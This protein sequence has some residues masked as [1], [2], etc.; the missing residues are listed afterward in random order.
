MVVELLDLGQKDW[1]LY[2]DTMCDGS[3][4]SRRELRIDA[5][6]LGAAVSLP[7]HKESKARC[8]LIVLPLTVPKPG[9][10]WSMR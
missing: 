3:H 8:P 1:I 6:R 4:R 5:S 10:K 2:K 9:L 7:I